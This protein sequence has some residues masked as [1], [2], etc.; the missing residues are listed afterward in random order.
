MAF[1][2]CFINPTGTFMLLKFSPLCNKLSLLVPEG[3]NHSIISLIPKV[4]GP[5]VMTQFRPISLCITVYKVISKIIVARIR[6]L[7]QQLISPNQVSYVFGRHISDNIMIAQE[8]LFKFR[9]S[10]GQKGF[11]A[12]KVDLSKAYHRLSWQFIQSVLYEALFPDSL[13]KLIMSCITS[14]SFQISFNGQL[15]DSFK[16]QR[17]IRQGDPLSPYIFVLCMEKL[18]HLIQ[19]AVDIGE[20]KA[21]RASQSGP[22]VSHLFFADDLMLFAE[23]S[24]EQADTLKQCLDVFCSLSGQSVSY[25]KSLIYCSPNTIKDLVVDI[26]NTC[27]SPLTS[28]LGK[29]LGMPLVHSRVTKYTYA[30][31]LEKAQSRLCSWKCKALSMAGRHTLIQSVT[32][33]IPIYIM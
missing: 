21:V 15:T 30:S 27:G 16:A 28:D 25:D 31:L 19:I 14:T 29:Y 11:F 8:L 9:N 12:L 23:A 10:F 26:S 6:P 7:M 5:Q 3:L 33:A 4:P 20:W 22:K 13:V 32:A 1:L 17:G 2:L 24:Q 18:S